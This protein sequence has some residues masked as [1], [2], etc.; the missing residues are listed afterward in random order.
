MHLMNTEQ[1]IVNIINNVHQLTTM[2][3]MKVLNKHPTKL[4]RWLMKLALDQYVFLKNHYILS[5]YDAQPSREKEDA[6]WVMLETL[7]GLEDL[8]L[9]LKTVVVAGS[10]PIYE[11][12]FSK[13]D[14]TG[15][16]FVY[17]VVS[18]LNNNPEQIQKLHLLEQYLHN[19]DYTNGKVKSAK[20]IVVS[21]D[22]TKVALPKSY[23]PIMHCEVSYELGK[24]E[25][26][27]VI[28]VINQKKGE[29]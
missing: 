4:A 23:Y 16:L 2:Q 10:K 21:G 25:N 3:L 12:V 14:D 11:Y 24:R 17:Y 18:I 13:A 28:R 15:Q 29:E 7:E 6:M 26:P 27:P 9:F 5:S 22:K 19:T 20:I 8:P 1:N